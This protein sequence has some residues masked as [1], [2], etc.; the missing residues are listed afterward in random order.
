M[1]GTPFGIGETVLGILDSDQQRKAINTATDMM[2]EFGMKNLDMYKDMW[3]K[4]EENFRPYLE[5]GYEGIDQLK[6][7][8]PELMETQLQPYSQAFRDFELTGVEQEIDPNTGLV[9]APTL[10]R[11]SGFEFDPNDP[12][13]L[14]KK[15]EIDKQTDTWLAKQGL[16]DSRAEETIKR[17]AVQGLVNEEVDKQYGRSVDER[18]YLN[19]LAMSQYGMDTQSGNALY[20]RL[21]DRRNR[22]MAADESRLSLLG[23]KYGMDRDLFSTRYGLATDLAKYG[24]GAAGSTGS[25]SVPYAQGMGNTLSGMGNTMA[26]SQLANANANTALY[27]NMMNNMSN[28]GNTGWNIYSMIN[29]RRSQPSYSNS[30]GGWSPSRY[31]GGMNT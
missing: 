20:D 11:S 15:A 17:D 5:L 2:Y 23:Q 16:T 13:Y 28:Q 6:N 26:G 27:Q 19:N 18:N 3:E 29:A 30:G 21:N 9:Q 25:I 1:S 12:V 24:A 8:I 7:S 4:S 31:G 22:M 14:A 10:D